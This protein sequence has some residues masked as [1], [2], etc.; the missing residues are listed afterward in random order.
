MTGMEPGDLLPGVTVIVVPH[1]DDGVLACGGTIAQIPHKK[2]VH[3]VYATDGRRSPA[4]L[5][6]W[7]DSVPVDLADVRAKEA[8]EAMGLLGIPKKNIHFLNL[9]DGR[10]RHHIPA[11]NRLLKE[12]IQS[13]KPTHI[14][15]PFRYDR[16]VD[17]LALN[18]VIT[19]AYQKGIFSAELIEYFVYY[20][21]KLLPDK[22]VR[23]YIRPQHLIEMSIKNASAQKRAALDCFKSQTTRFFEWQTRPNLTPLLLDEVSQAPELFLPYDA[24]VPGASIFTR[25]ITFIR[26]AHRLE[27]FLKKQKDQTIAIWRRIFKGNDLN[28]S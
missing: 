26:L 10:L 28:V 27:P 2:N 25:Y 18:R 16:H 3:I 5:L 8:K 20:R 6:P 14:L 17:H 15:I 9:P 24:A 22:D 4:P 1:M 21:W 7:R 23:L 13:I 19:T 11:L 12:L